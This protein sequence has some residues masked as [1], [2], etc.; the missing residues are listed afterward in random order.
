MSHGSARSGTQA[1][2]AQADLQNVSRGNDAPINEE[3]HTVRMTI[4]LLY[5]LIVSVQNK[6]ATI[7]PHMHLSENRGITFIITNYCLYI[8]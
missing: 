5:T 7:P 4:L 8:L 3:E 6:T 2:K 1:E